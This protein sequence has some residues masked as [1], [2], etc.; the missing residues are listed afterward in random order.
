MHHQQYSFFP[1]KYRHNMN[2]NEKQHHCNDMFNRTE[3]TTF[4]F[5][6]V[7]TEITLLFIVNLMPNYFYTFKFCRRTQMHTHTTQNGILGMSVVYTCFVLYAIEIENI[8]P[9]VWNNCIP[10]TCNNIYA[11]N[12]SSTT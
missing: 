1:S 8:E 7:R 9:L 12:G 2:S 4:F 6:A 5:S 10:T 3:V 11:W